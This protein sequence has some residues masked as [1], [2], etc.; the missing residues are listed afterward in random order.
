[1]TV[2]PIDLFDEMLEL[3]TTLFFEHENELF[4]RFLEQES[5]ALIDVG[6]GNGA[7]LSRLHDT[8]PHLPFIGLEYEAGIFERAVRKK[9]DGLDFQ[10]SSYESASVEPSSAGAIVA[11]LVMQHISDRIQFAEW[12]YKHMAPGGHL[13]LLDVDENAL[14]V[15]D[16]LP[17]FSQLYVQSRQ[18]IQTWLSFA[19]RLKLEMTHAGFAHLR[20][21]RYRLKAEDQVTKLKLYRYMIC[22]TELYTQEPISEE[23]EKELSAWLDDD[24]CS[25][26]IHMFGLEFQKQ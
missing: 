22:V 23:R 18:S 9:T 3:T 4:F 5:S 13:L 17:L 10:L 6:C 8:Y 2:H 26:E 19:D 21:E 12:A 11:R 20:T 25:H 7:Y 16:R 15:N 24:S 14:Q 1:M